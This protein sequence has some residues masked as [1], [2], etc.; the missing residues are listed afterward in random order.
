[1]SDAVLV[2]PTW[3]RALATLVDHVP[4]AL[5]WT[6]LVWALVGLDADPPDIPP[7]NFFDRVVDYIQARPERSLLAVVGLFAI[8][9]GWPLAFTPWLGS[10]PGKRLLGLT[11]VDRTGVRPRLGRLLGWAA[12]RLPSAFLAGAGLWWAIVDPER[13]ALHDRIAGVWVIVVGRRSA[14]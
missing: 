1:M 11:V 6:A 10:T 3:R 13:R 14:R 12:A 7:W 2:A 9:I 5:L 8:E 4:I